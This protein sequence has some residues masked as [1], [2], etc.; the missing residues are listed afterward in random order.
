V[1][2]QSAREAIKRLAPVALV[3]WVRSRRAVSAPTAQADRYPSWEE[4]CHAAGS[5]DNPNFNAFGVERSANRQADGS[6][7]RSC[8]LYSIAIAAAPAREVIDFGGATGD[9]G[10]EF[11][12]EFPNSVYTVVESPSMVS[13]MR[14]KGVV[15]YQTELPPDCD[16]FFTSG[17][18]QYVDSPF[19]VLS[20]AF[21]SARRAVVLVRNSFSYEEIFRVQRSALFQNGNGPIPPGYENVEIAYPHRTINENRVTELAIKHGF[22]CVARLEEQSGVLP[23]SDKV[24]GKQLAFLK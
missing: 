7:L 5:Y 2:T 14:G 22:K 10:I 13:I 8:L 16:I 12:R 11:I 18:L 3:D 24:Y 9:I 21:S 23:Y 15:R 1:H 6:A 17:T 19:D 20:K 4:A